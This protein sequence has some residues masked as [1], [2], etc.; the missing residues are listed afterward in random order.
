MKISACMIVKNEENVLKLTLPDLSRGAD[1][2]I[3]VD[4]GST[5]GTIEVAKQFGA[6]VYHFPWTD[7]FSAA[8]NESLKYATGDF[9][10]WVDADEFIAEEKIQKLRSVLLDIKEDAFYLPVYE[11]KF[12]QKE[13]TKFY[14]RLKGFKNKKGIH[15]ERAFN[16]QVYD[17]SHQLVSSSLF[18]GGIEIFHWGTDLSEEKT[19]L[20]RERN[21]RILKKKLQ[22]EPNDPYFHFML[23]NNYYETGCF[24]LAFDCYGEVVKLLPNNHI[25][26]SSRI[27]R[28]RIL[29]KQK[30]FQ[31]AYAELKSVLNLDSTNAEAF[32][33][34][35]SIYISTNNLPYAIK[36][37]EHAS[38]LVL[39][40]KSLKSFNVDDY[41]F[42]PR[43][44]LANAYLL[45]GQKKEALET[46]TALGPLSP[47]STSMFCVELRNCV[48][49]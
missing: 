16:E 10:L 40:Q 1:E 6:M 31:D 25:A 36:I 39:P 44:L 7:D 35:G 26:I 45:N 3:L 29:V 28:A 37:L 42:L 2:I 4:T 9:I 43:F 30:K 32:N 33:L 24:D 14:F 49:R 47:C 8:R 48:W 41:T 19:K 46:F 17:L 13:G 27:K 5:D 22:D 21:L 18:L 12:G 20:K 11:A 34:I 23:A 38:T 15:F